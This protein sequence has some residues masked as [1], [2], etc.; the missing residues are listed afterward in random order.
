MPWGGN[1]RGTDE[2]RTA[3][4]GWEEESEAERV[5]SEWALSGTLDYIECDGRSWRAENRDTT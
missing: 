3:L 2:E 4:A 5:P 1:V